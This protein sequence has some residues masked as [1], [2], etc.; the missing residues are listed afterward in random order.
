MSITIN[1]STLISSIKN[2]VRRLSSSIYKIEEDAIDSLKCN[3]ERLDEESESYITSINAVSR[4]IIQKL[5]E[6][7]NTKRIVQIIE[8]SSKDALL[9]IDQYGFILTVNHATLNIFGYNESELAEINIKDIIPQ[10][11]TNR[12]S[13]EWIEINGIK[14]NASEVLLEVIT[15]R[16]SDKCES[17]LNKKYLIIA[18]D[19]SYSK[20]LEANNVQLSN[21]VDT[22]IHGSPNPIYHKDISLRYVGCNKPFE[23]LAG[24]SFNELFGKTVFD[25]FPDDV[26]EYANR[27]DLELITS[28]NPNDD[29][30]QI[31]SCKVRNNVSTKESEVVVYSTPVLDVD[32][33][34]CGIVGTIID[35]TDYLKAKRS[36]DH[37]EAVLNET[38]GPVFITD[39]TNTILFANTAILNLLEYTFDEMFAQY[40]SLFI[41]SMNDNM[42]TIKSKSGT[43]YTL[44]LKAIKIPCDSEEVTVMNILTFI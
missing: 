12:K 16:I 42:I 17:N 31:Y 19:I 41:V 1:K 22:L 24:V 25:I 4:R 36:A 34:I 32:N 37:L 2:G 38:T 43:E 44:Q 15:K 28:V 13:S 6:E 8:D 10:F 5:S 27:R 21:I 29:K 23:K 33:R 9:T 18:K 14:K 26:A 11:I 30:R 20:E 35:L 39:S 3:L 40:A 7:A